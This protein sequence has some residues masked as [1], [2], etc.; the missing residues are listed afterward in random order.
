MKSNKTIAIAAVLFALLSTLFAMSG[1]G[2]Q[3]PAQPE[4]A[5]EATQVQNE[6]VQLA[7]EG[8]QV[9]QNDESGQEEKSAQNKQANSIDPKNLKYADRLKEKEKS[10]FVSFEI[11][12]SNKLPE[13]E[14]IEK[15]Y[16]AY[17]KRFFDMD[18]KSY[19]MIPKLFESKVNLDAIDNYKNYGIDIIELDK[20]GF[21]GR[22]GLDEK[23]T[24]L[25]SK[26]V[27]EGTVI[28][29]I[30]YP[31]NFAIFHNCYIVKVDSILKGVEYFD[32]NP[33]YLRLYSSDGKRYKK[34][35]SLE[36]PLYQTTYKK[37]KKYAFVIGTS[38][39]VAYFTDRLRDAQKNESN[40]EFEY[41]SLLLSTTSFSNWQLSPVSIE[42]TRAILNEI[43]K[44]NDSKNFYNRGR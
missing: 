1:D 7:E 3:Q 9:V 25:L 30:N 28:D 24:L 31:D 19:L 15:L 10:M 14:E 8:L 34:D 38:S 16:N 21:M 22:H 11:L 27:I 17:K 13:I 44:L 36:W 32:Y 12:K 42:Q 43:D 26:I 5:T 37:D 29:S 4:K 6:Q 40:E 20:S 18:F 35:G 41:L 23:S 33:E 2:G 39:Y